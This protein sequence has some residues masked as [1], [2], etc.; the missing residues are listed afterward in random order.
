MPRCIRDCDGDGD[1]DGEE[2]EGDDTALFEDPSPCPLVPLVPL[3][4]PLSLL[5]VAL[6][7]GRPNLLVAA[8]LSAISRRELKEGGCLAAAEPLLGLLD[9]AEDRP[10]P[11]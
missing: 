2:G 4:A 5:S 9:V 1:G 6:A 10:R 3:S 7:A 11:P 8:L